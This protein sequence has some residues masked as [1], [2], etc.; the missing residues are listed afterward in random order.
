MPAIAVDN[1]SKAYR[2]GLDGTARRRAADTG[3]WAGMAAAWFKAPLA[4]ISKSLRDTRRRLSED[5]SDSP[6]TFWALRDANFE[7]GEGRTLGLIGRNGAGKS[8]LLKILSRIVEPTSGRAIMNGRTASLLEVGTGFHPELTG[9]ENVYLNGAI[10]GMRREEI[11]RKFDDIVEFSEVGHF[12][13]TPVKRYSSGMYVRLAFSVAAHL[14]PKIMIV[15]EVLAVGD[16]AFQKK[17]LGKMNDAARGGRTIVFVSHQMDA[18]AR[19]CDGVRVVRD[20]RVGE[21]Q[22]VDDG[23]AEYLGGVEQAAGVPVID[24]P[25]T[26]DRDRPPIFSDLVMTGDDGR[27][28]G[29]AAVVPAGSGITFTVEMKDF[30]E[31]GNFTCGVALLNG[32][33]QRV[34]LF[35]SEYHAGIVFRG[36]T[37]KTLRCRVPSLPLGP[38]SY[39]VELVAAD[40]FKILERVERAAD[41]EVTFADLL[42]TGKVPNAQQSTVVLPAE[43]EEVA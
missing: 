28:L 5:W 26:Q 23:I 38:G 6:D 19:L 8:T 41:L 42:G 9:R 1:L 31:P 17:C 29:R 13:D 39:A 33:G 36:S 27:D 14:E 22:S 21:E 34:A 15:D 30:D 37:R 16:A 32:R 25:R 12:L 24:R 40:G 10:L 4:G 43:W 35:H 11:R 7:V 20:G 18:I 3:G 2:I